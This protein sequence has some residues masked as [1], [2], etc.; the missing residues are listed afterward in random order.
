MG[1]VYVPGSGGF[2]DIYDLDGNHLSKTSTIGGISL[3]PGTYIF[4]IN[5]TR[6]T[7]NVHPG[8]NIV[9]F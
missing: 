5:G 2:C 3:F 6:Q 9:N 7:V 1:V 8:E 4:S